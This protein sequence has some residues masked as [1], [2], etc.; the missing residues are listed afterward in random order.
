LV[1]VAKPLAWQTH[2]TQLVYH[3][4]KPPQTT[5]YDAQHFQRISEVKKAPE[6][7]E[8]IVHNNMVTAIITVLPRPSLS[9][10]TSKSTKRK[11][12]AKIAMSDQ[13]STPPNG[14]PVYGHEQT[15]NGNG[16]FNG[17]VNGTV[18]GERQRRR[19]GS[20]RW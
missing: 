20:R 15:V 8:V 7:Q 6:V 11:R 4:A 17:T 9:I 10:S 2:T 12:N 19:H 1:F 16:T 3:V 14:A 5:A 13:K 18:N